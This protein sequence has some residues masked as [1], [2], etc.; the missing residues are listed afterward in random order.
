[1]QRQGWRRGRGGDCIQLDIVDAHPIAATVGIVVDASKAHDVIEA[2]TNLC[3]HA[4][5]TELRG[6]VIRI[7]ISRVDDDLSLYQK[8]IEI[9]FDA[10]AGIG[11]GTVRFTRVQIDRIESDRE[12]VIGC[13]RGWKVEV[14]AQIQVS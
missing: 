12:K 9:N 13:Q 11:N 14:I 7:Q 4:G 2:G 6:R 1:Q 5:Q 3:V 8:A 10:E